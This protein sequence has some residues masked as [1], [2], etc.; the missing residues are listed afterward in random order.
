MSSSSELPHP[1][2]ATFEEKIVADAGNW[3]Q[4]FDCL[5]IGPVL[6]KDEVLLVCASSDASLELWNNV[7]MLDD[8][9]H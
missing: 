2:F 5:V 3:I 4:R 6:G 8:Q 7:V 9:S 1:T